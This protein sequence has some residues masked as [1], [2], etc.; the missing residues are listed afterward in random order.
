MFANRL[1]KRVSTSMKCS[2]GDE[3]GS[4]GD[5][6]QDQKLE[7]PETG[8]NKYKPSVSTITDFSGDY[9]FHSR[10]VRMFE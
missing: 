10:L 1:I 5:P 9:I 3:K 7:E 2:I 8:E 4:H 6:N